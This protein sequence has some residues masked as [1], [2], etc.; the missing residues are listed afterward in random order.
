MT[1]TVYDGK[2]CFYFVFGEVGGSSTLRIYNRPKGIRGK[3]YLGTNGLGHITSSPYQAPL[4]LVLLLI[5]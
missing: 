2:Q 5:F 4:T 1:M 3:K